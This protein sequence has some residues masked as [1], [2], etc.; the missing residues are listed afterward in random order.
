M[1]YREIDV[2]CK[3]RYFT[4]HLVEVPETG[5]TKYE[6]EGGGNFQEIMTSDVPKSKYTFLK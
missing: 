3:M 5:N 1:Q 4:T 6:V 2:E